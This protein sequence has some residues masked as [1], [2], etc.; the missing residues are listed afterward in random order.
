MRFR[1]TTSVPDTLLR[2][3][4]R[5]VQPSRVTR[6]K[7]EVRNAANVHGGAS[8]TNARRVG[9]RFDLTNHYPR[10]IRPYQRGQLKGRRT[11]TRRASETYEAH[12]LYIKTFNGGRWVPVKV[13][14][15][16]ANLSDTP[17]KA[18]IGRYCRSLLVLI[19]E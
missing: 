11:L 19:A 8:W 3:V 1:N 17:T 7:V 15:N 14:D 12:I 9:L 16:L 5:F 4:I 6:V 10:W 18:Q 2:E 13:A